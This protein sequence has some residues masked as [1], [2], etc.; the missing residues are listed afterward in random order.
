ME[1]EPSL[2]DYY[3]LHFYLVA[4]YFLYNDI[5]NNNIKV[6]SEGGANIFFGLTHRLGQINC[7]K[8]GSK[9]FCELIS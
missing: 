1:L 8:K 9:F 2:H 6:N 7:L 4:E 3:G 5:I